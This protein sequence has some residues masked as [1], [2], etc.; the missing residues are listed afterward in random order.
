[1]AFRIGAKVGCAAVRVIG[2]RRRAHSGTASN[3]PRR[4][5]VSPVPTLLELP[6]RL[7][8]L[9]TALAFLLSPTLLAAQDRETDAEWL[10]RCRENGYANSD[11]RARAC[12]VRNVP[13]RLS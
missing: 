12:E 11:Y 6:M 7:V 13:V 2:P 4:P 5:G 8:R 1:M 10:E 3:L 9:S